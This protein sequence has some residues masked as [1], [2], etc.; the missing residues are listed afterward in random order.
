MIE[1]CGTAGD[2]GTPSKGT[3]LLQETY[4]KGEPVRV[5]RAQNKS[6]RY[7]PKDG[8]RY[9]G[10]YKITDYEIRDAKEAKIR[11]TLKRVEGQ[12]PIRFQ[13]VE[14]RPSPQELAER[15]KIRAFL[16][17]GK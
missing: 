8:I 14:K 16:D 2:N 10:L 6:S 12:D 11:F 5:L 1:Y 9:D 17:G 7:A 15:V 3:Q 4:R 13:G